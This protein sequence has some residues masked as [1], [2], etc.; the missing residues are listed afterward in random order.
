MGNERIRLMVLVAL[1][2]STFAAVQVTARHHR[3]Q[4]RQPNWDVVPYEMDG[5][6]GFESRFDPIYGG[7]PS[8]T[9]LLRVYRRGDQPPVIL[10]VGF[11]GELAKIL[12]IHTPEL[13]YP[14]E[15]WEILRS[16]KSSA[17][18]FR[19]EQIQAKEILVDKGGNRR[20]VVWWYNAGP[21][22]IQTRIRNVYAMLAM[23]MITGRTDGSMVRVETP[24]GSGGEAE[25]EKRV[26]EFQKSILP[27]LDR[28]LPL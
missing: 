15:G 27:Q 28:A 7:D 9:R 25:A 17:G 22:P 13:C 4:R 3:Q 26:G 19:S 6:S 18:S 8:D 20:L 14:A 2:A 24:L 23:S 10:Y 12:D 1:F 16:G 5:W 21:R 11:F